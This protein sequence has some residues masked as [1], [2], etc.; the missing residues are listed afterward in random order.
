MPERTYQATYK[1]KA[2]PR[3]AGKVELQFT[4][5]GTSKVLA[6]AAA[7]QALQAM[8]EPKVDYTGPRLERVEGSPTPPDTVLQGESEANSSEGDTDSIEQATG[9]SWGALYG[10][11]NDDSVMMSDPADGMTTGAEV[12]QV[13]ESAGSQS[14]VA[15]VEGP[16]EFVP[17][18]DRQLQELNAEI[19]ALLPG[20]RLRREGIAAEVYHKSEGWGSSKVKDYIKCPATVAPSTGSSF[21]KKPTK[22][23]RIGTAYHAATLEPELFQRDYEDVKASPLS[24]QGEYDD[25]L[26]MRDATL[27]NIGW[28][29][30]GGSSEVS[31]WYRLNEHI[32]LKCRI[33]YELPTL[34]LDLKSAAD[35]SDQAIADAVDRFGYALQQEHYKIVS[36]KPQFAFLFQQN[37]APFLT[38]I[39]VQLDMDLQEY[40]QLKLAK[41]YEDIKFSIVNDY[42]PVNRSTNQPDEVQTLVVGLKAWKRRELESM[43]IEA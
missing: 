5:T 33:D 11:P 4:V 9:D 29:L 20:E 31:Y 40:A 25:V 10:S 24:N 19:A 26:K 42:W 8:N 41:T 37:Q 38:S 3:K 13:A 16:P 39:P 43:R 6:K 17:I 35:V 28:L 2:G 1:P 32:V 14:S 22:A 12:N 15:E 23:M 21:D 18:F 36:G 34:P 7:E 30:Q 27:N